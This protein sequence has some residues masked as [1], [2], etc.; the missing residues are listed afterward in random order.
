MLLHRS[1]NTSMNQI[2]IS[3]EEASTS[4]TSPTSPPPL[5]QGDETLASALGPSAALLFRATLA[6]L[7]GLTALALAF[8]AYV[9][10]AKVEIAH[11]VFAVVFQEIGVSCACVAVSFVAVLTTGIDYD[12][13]YLPLVLQAVA[14][15][16]HQWSW[17]T[18]TWL[19]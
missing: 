15:H 1:D 13:Y 10:H 12:A 16:F 17:L 14:M 2:N 4:F 8:Y 9:M 5:G 6:L 3:S 19:R 11:P 18:I 7:L